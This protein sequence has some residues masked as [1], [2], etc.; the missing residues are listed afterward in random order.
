MPRPRRSGRTVRADE[1]PDGVATAPAR[2]GPAGDEQADLGGGHDV[3][4][5]GTQR[6]APNARPRSGAQRDAH[7]LAAHLQDDVGLERALQVVP[8]E[9]VQPIP[10]HLGEIGQDRLVRLASGG[11]HQ[12]RPDLFFGE[13]VHLIES[14]LSRSMHGTGLSH[15]CR[16]LGN[17]AQGGNGRPAGHRDGRISGWEQVQPGVQECAAAAEQAT[18]ATPL[19]A[20]PRCT[21]PPSTR[22]CP[23]S[24]DRNDS[25]LGAGSGAVD[26]RATRLPRSSG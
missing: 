7:D 6:L 21:V 8:P 16:S 3:L 20:P 9:V 25:S 22:S 23:I 5:P 17:H 14:S 15:S 11:V 24:R 18:S 1:R 19:P 4:A 10:G 2:P 13:C 26:L 12:R